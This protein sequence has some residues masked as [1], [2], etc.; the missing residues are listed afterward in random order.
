[1]DNIDTNV[2][3][4]NDPFSLEEQDH[5]KLRLYNKLKGSFKIEPYIDKIKN[6][7]QRQW[8]SRYRI[9]AHTLHIE[10]GRYTR[11][12]TPLHDRKC[13]YCDEKCIDDEKH[14]ILHC[15]TFEIKRQCF[16]SRVRVLFPQFDQ[17]TLDEKLRFI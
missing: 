2:N 14:F 5:N 6:R 3:E 1:M 8:L 9:S 16:V 10:T 17:M 12:V 15:N 7:N 11:P 13:Y 4:L